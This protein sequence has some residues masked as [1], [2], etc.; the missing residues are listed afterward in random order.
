VRSRT[1]CLFFLLIACAALAG[2][3]SDGG[4]SSTTATATTTAV[5]ALARRAPAPGEIVIRGEASP[6]THGPYEF[7]GR[8]LV[9]FEQ[10]APEDPKL[11][12]GSQTPFSAALT[13][14]QGHTTGAIELF[15]AATRSG[16]R[17]LTIHGR[18]DVEVSFGD[19][20]YVVRFTP[21]AA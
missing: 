21:R 7:N 13:R 9:R 17:E 18:Y 14:R 3:G 8:Y 20:P 19:F 15:Q 5:P 10:Y 16:R 1:V 2:C 11:D 6:A 4:S 12:F